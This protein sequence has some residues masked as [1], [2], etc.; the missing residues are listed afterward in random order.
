MN[1]AIIENDKV[2][3]IIVADADFIAEHYPDA[4][5]ID[6]I[7]GIGWSYIDGTFIAPEPVVDETE[8]I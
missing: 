2:V 4:I 1:Y 3:N 8:T 6:E 5:E 7:A